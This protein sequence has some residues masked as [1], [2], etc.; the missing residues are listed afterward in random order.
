MVDL[1]AEYPD[2]TPGQIASMCAL[3]FQ[4]CRASKH[5]GQAVLANGP[6]P[7]RA[8]RHSSRSEEITDPEERRLTVIHLHAQGW[9]ISTIARFLDVSPRRPTP[10]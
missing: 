8:T 9:S 4:G 10:S 1:K 3:Q 7:F 6:R 2:F 5:T